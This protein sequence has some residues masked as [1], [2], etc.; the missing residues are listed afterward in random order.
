MAES[1]SYAFT[2]AEAGKQ[3]GLRLLRGPDDVLNE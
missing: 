1:H 3:G 2:L